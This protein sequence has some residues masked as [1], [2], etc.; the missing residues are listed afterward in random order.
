M[1]MKFLGGKYTMGLFL[2]SEKYGFYTLFVLAFLYLTLL[3][4]SKLENN[5]YLHV[6]LTAA[7]SHFH[8]HKYN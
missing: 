1:S 5:N 2:L 8:V 4:H 7:S 6:W 3:F